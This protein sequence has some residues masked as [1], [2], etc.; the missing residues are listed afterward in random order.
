MIPR[1][2][3]LYAAV[4]VRQPLG[5]LLIGERANAT[6]SKKFREMLL[7]NDFDGMVG[8][9]Q[10]QEGAHVLDVSVAYAGRDEAADMQKFVRMAVTAVTQPLMI[11]STNP[12]VIETALKYYPGRPV[13]NS[14]N[15]E[16]GGKTLA[17]IAPLAREH[18]AMLVALTI[19]EQGMALTCARKVAVALRLRDMLVND[20]GLR[21]Q[22]IMFDCLTFTI[23]SGDESLF[24]AGIE[25]LNAIKE[26]NRLMPRC[27]TVLGVSNISFGLKPN[28]RHVVNSVFLQEAVNAGLTAA[29]V[30]AAKIRPLSEISAAEKELALALIYNRRDNGNDPLVNIIN[31]FAATV[32]NSAQTATALM[33]TPEEMLAEKIIKGSK[34]GLADVLAALLERYGAVDII[35]TLLIPTMQKIGERFGKGEMLLPFVLQAAETMRRAVNLLKPHMP[36]NQTTA[37]KKV[38]LAT[39]Q[40]DVHDIGKNLVDIILSNNG[41][42]VVNIGIKQTAEQIMHEAKAHNVDMIGLSGLLVKSALIMKESLPQYQAAGLDIPVL[43]GGAALTPRFVAEE[44]APLY[45]KPVVYCQDAFDA[46]KALDDLEQNRLTS[47]VTEKGDFVIIAPVSSAAIGNAPPL[48]APFCGARVL[49]DFTLKEVLANLNKQSLFRNRWGYHQGGM[50][51]AEHQKLLRETAEPKFVALLAKLEPVLEF[52]AA[53]GY[54]SAA[55]NGNML[56]LTDNGVT[57]DFEFPRQN[58]PQGLCIADYFKTP[59]GNQTIAPLFAVTL[60]AKATAAVKA[61]FDKNAYQDYL[62]LHGLMAELTDALAQ[63]LHKRIAAELKLAVLTHSP[64]F[65]GTRY[66]F[67]YPACPSLELNAPL[68][69]L[70]QAEKLGLTLTASLMIEPEYSTCGIIACHPASKYFTV[71]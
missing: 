30:D 38:L 67:G 41:Y 32:D 46:L 65:I 55:A 35:N 59:K 51:A 48:S 63:T 19:D 36:H 10:A 50:S 13:I 56:T 49:N 52:K 57:H 20:Y 8:V 37:R 9:L 1:L 14:V 7:N 25:T 23:G 27:H 12:R 39:V 69:K 24:T 34:D 71:N 2:A 17:Q 21:D 31:H 40:G 43:L 5:P 66:G 16:D 70:L 3:S 29:I 44:C 22:D 61:A 53:Y 28:C 18:A 64:G 42:E 26:I 11:D 47:T 15:L 68:L 33:Q 54:F 58:L 45:Q 6:G 60:G 4:D 62:L